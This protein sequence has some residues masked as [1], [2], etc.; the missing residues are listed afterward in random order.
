M[1][2]SDHPSHMHESDVDG[3][4]ANPKATNEE[5]KDALDI[6]PGKGGV[7]I[8]GEIVLENPALLAPT[9]SIIPLA[10]VRYT[11]TSSLDSPKLSP[12]I[13]MVFATDDK[14]DLDSL[15]NGVRTSATNVAILTGLPLLPLS[16]S[17]VT[18]AV[19]SPRGI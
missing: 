7:E 10:V 15:T 9:S 19:N 6:M 3:M 11:C 17:R 5:L 13:K 1:R 8:D 14:C 2:P 18:T 4:L 16:L 12:L